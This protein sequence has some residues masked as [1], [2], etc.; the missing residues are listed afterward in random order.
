MNGCSLE[1]H[2]T[3]S[4][5]QDR[6]VEPGLDVERSPAKWG[7]QAGTGS[8]LLRAGRGGG[9]PD[10]RGNVVPGHDAAPL[11]R[12]AR[13]Y[14]LH[15]D[16]RIPD[17]ATAGVHFFAA[18]RARSRSA[19]HPCHPL[20]E[21]AVT[22]SRRDGRRCSRRFLVGGRRCGGRSPSGGGQGGARAAP[23]H[24]PSRRSSGREPRL[25]GEDADLAVLGAPAVLEYWRCTPAEVVPFLTKPVS[26]RMR[27]P[28]A[29][30]SLSAMRRKRSSSS[31]SQVASA[32]S[33]ITRGDCPHHR[34]DSSRCHSLEGRSGKTAPDVPA[35]NYTPDDASDQAR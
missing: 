31:R 22:A 5:N 24:A 30:P 16:Q 28:S 11:N 19:V 33:S 25:G 12:G 35:A 1:S 20:V 17:S 15:R 4:K 6:R 9:R 8:G 32:R 29:S 3:E 10:G 13:L 27:T 14:P 23:R 2:E 7:G 18:D 21:G 26:S 34:A